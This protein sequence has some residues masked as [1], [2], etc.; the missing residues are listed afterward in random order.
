MYA[1]NYFMAVRQAKRNTVKSD[2]MAVQGIGL[3]ELKAICGPLCPTWVKFTEY[4]DADWVTRMLSELWPHINKATSQVVR[5]TMEPILEANRP[6]IVSSM[7]FHKFE[8]GKDRE[9]AP[10]V[11]GNDSEKAPHV[12]GTTISLFPPVL[13]SLPPL[14]SPPSLPTPPSPCAPF[15]VP[16]WH[17]VAQDGRG[18]GPGDYGFSQVLLAR[19]PILRNPSS[20]PSPPSLKRPLFPFLVAGIK[21][22]KTGADKDQVIMDLLIYW[23]SDASIVLN[24]KTAAVTLQV[25]VGVGRNRV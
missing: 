18:G 5:E 3:N 14:P 10:H 17:Q 7:T 25:Q 4:D 9:K 6:S 2:L 22:H 16:S 24:I 11:E 13:S 1:W 15:S 12:E 19:N 8:L 20:P 21:L 23:Q